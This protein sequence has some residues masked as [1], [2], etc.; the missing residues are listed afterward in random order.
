MCFFVFINDNDSKHSSKFSV[1]I[2]KWFAKHKR[3][4]RS[5][6]GSSRTVPEG[7]P[8]FMHHEN[9]PLGASDTVDPATVSQAAYDID[10]HS[11]VLDNVSDDY[12]DEITHHNITT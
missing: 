11:Y 9:T 7:L 2:R 8:T 6:T 3:G 4:N 1:K 12:I 5:S 10:H